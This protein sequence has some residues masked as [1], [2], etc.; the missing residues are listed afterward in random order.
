MNQPTIPGVQKGVRP[1]NIR[2]IVVSTLAE[3][4]R[5]TALGDIGPGP[6]A[7][8]LRE[9][10]DTIGGNGAGA[11]PMSPKTQE[12]LEAWK[13]VFAY[14]QKA[15]GKSRARQTNDKRE[16]VYAR[17]RRFSEAEI[18]K[19]IDGCLASE[20]N[21]EK[22]KI[23]LPY[24][25]RSDTALEE[26]IDAAGGM[27]DRPEHVLPDEVQAKIDALELKAMEALEGGDHETYEAT[28]KQIERIQRDGL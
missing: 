23:G 1:K 16:K 7:M 27:P 25:C 10:A 26:F 4:I 9:L 8:A 12:M 13:R 28:Q 22:G 5:R 2:T 6:L 11:E 19:A 18:L 21:V 17:L 20:W 14:W 3:L 15:S 24:I